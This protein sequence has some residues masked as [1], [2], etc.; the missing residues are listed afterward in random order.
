MQI[1]LVRG[2]AHR[3]FIRGKIIVVIFMH[4]GVGPSLFRGRS[5]AGARSNTW[6]KEAYND[7][8]KKAKQPK[9][10][11]FFTKVFWS[12]VSPFAI[13]STSFEHPDNFRPGTPTS[14]Q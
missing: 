9:I 11:F 7:M 14:T 12:S 2:F 4:R 1:R 5:C 10:T 8:Q 6:Y 3:G 13:H